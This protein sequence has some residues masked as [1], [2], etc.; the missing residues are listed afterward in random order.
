MARRTRVQITE[1]QTAPQAELLTATITAQVGEDTFTYYANYAEVACVPHDFAILFARVPAKLSPEKAEEA[2]A[3][4]LTLTSDVQIIVPTTLIDGLIRALTTQ[5]A[6]YEQ[7]FGAIHEP[8]G[9]SH[10]ESG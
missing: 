7:R 8:G 6:A 9:G 2:K 1:A 4:N 3:G 10:G 5:K